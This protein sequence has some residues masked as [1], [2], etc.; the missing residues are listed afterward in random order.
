MV[1]TK[2]TEGRKL[3][4]IKFMNSHFLA[5]LLAVN[6]IIG[7]PIND[8]KKLCKNKPGETITVNPPLLI[9]SKFTT[10]K[11][12]ECLEEYEIIISIS[13]PSKRTYQK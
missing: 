13:I 6:K 2:I 10:D 9:T 7:I 8:A 11:L 12:F 5:N 3:T 1:V 4:E